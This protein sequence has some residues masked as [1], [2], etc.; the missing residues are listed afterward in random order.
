MSQSKNTKKQNKKP[1]IFFR[2]TFWRKKGYYRRQSWAF[3]SVSHDTFFKE[4]F[5]RK[6]VAKAFLRAVL[7]PEAIELLDMNALEVLPGNFLTP[8]FKILYPD[9]VYRVPM[10]NSSG[11]I[12]GSVHFHVVLEHKAKNEFWSTFQIVRYVHYLE[13]EI[14]D[15]ADNANR[16]TV[17]FRIPAI[18]PIIIYHGQ[19]RFSAPDNVSEYHQ[20]FPGYEKGDISRKVKIIDLS[21]ISDDDLPNDPNCPELYA[22]MKLMKYIFQENF[23][24]KFQEILE[25]LLPYK[26]LKYKRINCLM[27]SY[28]IHSASYAEEEQFQRIVRKLPN[29]NIKEDEMPGLLQRERIKGKAEGLTEGEIKGKVEVILLFL[30]QIG[31]VPQPLVDRLNAIDPTNADRLNNLALLAPKCKT[32]EEFEKAM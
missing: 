7:E 4:I 10:K 3:R 13:S 19:S 29:Q 26:G 2:R 28:A 15:Q 5:R 6:D 17:E 25:S 31:H 8:E 21:T 20:E 24:E 12:V 22:S 11:E 27:W 18:L 23:I 32:I 14:V 1:R 30:S 9:M 16:L